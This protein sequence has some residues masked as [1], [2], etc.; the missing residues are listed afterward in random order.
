MGQLL[1]LHGE[2]EALAPVDVHCRWDA[3][4]DTEGSAPDRRAGWALSKPR[5]VQ[6]IQ[7]VPVVPAS[8]FDA[9]LDQRQA[10]HKSNHDPTVAASSCMWRQR[11]AKIPKAD[12]ASCPHPT[13]RL[14]GSPPGTK[15]WLPGGRAP[16]TYPCRRS[17]GRTR[18]AFS[19]PRGVGCT[20]VAGHKMQ[21]LFLLG[22]RSVS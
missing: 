15:I 5:Q 20:R 18:T 16:V 7:P 21:D 2:Y 11:P 12:R 10:H 9:S 19:G 1:T 4:T 13:R 22:L 8:V 17:G 3:S 14:L 6:H